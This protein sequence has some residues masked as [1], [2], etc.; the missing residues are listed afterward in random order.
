M[1]VFNLEAR[2][3]AIIVSSRLSHPA[4]EDQIQKSAPNCHYYLQRAV[5]PDWM[6]S[7]AL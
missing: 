1:T 3:T 6:G 7:S 2:K 5:T 4:Q